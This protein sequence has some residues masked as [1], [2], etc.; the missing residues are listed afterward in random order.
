MALVM[1]VSVFASS[2]GGNVLISHASDEIIVEDGIEEI[3]QTPESA[4]EDAVIEGQ[5]IAED[6]V[7]AE[8]Q[9]IAENQVIAEDQVTVEEQTLPEETL[10]EEEAAPDDGDLTIEEIVVVEEEEIPEELRDTGTSDIGETPESNAQVTDQN[11]TGVTGFPASTDGYSNNDIALL[12]NDATFSAD[13]TV[14]YQQSAARS[15]LDLVNEFRTSGDGWYWNEDNITKVECG[16]LPA[17]TYDYTLEEIA[18]QRAAE[19]A[20]FFSH[21]RPDGGTCWTAYGN[22]YVNAYKAE[23]I[24]A[25]YTS[26]E[27]VFNAWKEENEY[28]DDQGHRRNMLSSTYTSIGIACV[29]YNGYYYWVQEFSSLIDSTT[30]TP[31]ND[32]ETK[33]TVDITAD[34]IKSL[35][36]TSSVEKYEMLVGDSM[37]L[38]TLTVKLFLD[39]S[40]LNPKESA[41][42]GSMESVVDVDYSWAVGDTSC[43]G[44]SDG[45]LVAKQVGTTELYTTV[46]TDDV[47]IPVTVTQ[48]ITACTVTLDPAECS[49]TG[50]A[51]TPTVTVMDGTTALTEGT[52][53]TVSYTDN[54]EVGT[55]TVTVTGMGSYSGEVTVDFTISPASIS[56]AVITFPDEKY[57][58]Y[59]GAQEPEVTVTVNGKVLEADTDYIVAYS[60]NVNAGEATVTVTGQGNYTD[61]ATATFTIDPADIS[62]ASVTFSQ[63]SYTYDG[64]EQTPEATVTWNGTELTAGTDYTIVYDNN[65]NVGRAAVTITGKGN[66]TGTIEE[67]F[68]IVQASIEDATVTVNP[69][70]Y[71]YDGEEKE[72]SVTVTAADGTSLTEGTDYSVSYSDNINAGEA[73]VTVTGMG[74]YE[75][76][77]SATFT[78]NQ[79]D[80]TDADVAVAQGSYTY[81]GSGQTPDVTVTVN[82][83]VLT[84]GT[85]YTVAY[86]DNVNAGEATVTVTGTGNYTG[87]A[88]TTFTIDPADLT[89]A[90]VTFAQDSYTYDGSEQTPDVT[91]T[92]DGTELTAGTDYT[93]VYDNNVNVGTAAVTITG[94]GNYTG[95]IEG[96][97]AIVQASIEDATITIDPDT[98]T[99]DGEEKEPSVTVTFNGTE[100]TEEI[101][102]TVSYSENIDAGEAAVTVTGMGNYEGTVAATFTINQADLTDADVA[103]AQ[104]SYTYDGSGQTPD[105][106]V[107]VNGKVLTVR[108]DYI[109]AYSN[110]VNAGEATVTVTGTGNYTG[111]ATA[112]FTIEQADISDASVTFV[113]DSYTYDGSAKTPA[114]TVTVNGTELTAGTDYT[115]VYSSNVNAGEATVT[116]TGTGNYT[117][118]ATADFTIDPADLSD[119]AVSVSDAVYS[120]EALSPEVTVT[121]ADG[122]VLKEDEDYTVTYSDN[123]DVGTGT[124]T[125][126]GIGNYTGTVTGTF[127][128]RQE[129]TEDLFTVDTD[130]ETYTGSEITKGITSDLTEDTDYTVSYADNTDAGTATIT[131]TGIGSYIGEL[132]YQFEIEPADITDAAVKLS[133][134]EYTYDGQ[135]KT[136]T[137]TVTLADGTVLTENTDYTVSYKNNIEAG[138]A[139]VTVT[140][141]GNYTGTVTASFTIDPAPETETE[142]ETPQ[143]ETETPQTET[144]TPQTETNAPQTETPQTE[145]SAPQTETS[146]PQTEAPQTET[147]AP[148]TEAPQ[149]ETETPQTDKPDTSKPSATTT[150]AL[151]ML[152]GTASKKTISLSWNKVQNAD[153]YVVYGKQCGKK[154][155]KLATIEGRKNTTWK[156]SGL[157][158]ATRYKFKV[159]AYKII[160]G[161]AKALKSSNMVHLVT[162]GNRFTNIKSVKVSENALSL[163][164]GRSRKVTAT[165]TLLDSNKRLVGHMGKIRYASSDKSVAVVSAKGK[166]TAVGK[167]TCVV[168]AYAPSGS[169]K[170][171][172]VTVK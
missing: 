103:V 97:F 150:T 16:V 73:A 172:T 28:Y 104:G 98:Y 157:K 159:Y 72:P 55:A 23:N 168:Y 24:A 37:G 144:N 111:E 169:R 47:I 140:G 155:R 151:L 92:V 7:I 83:K 160:N 21:T 158:Q 132:T 30:V 114:A 135:E 166:I 145:T 120:G 112:T 94:M 68:D 121:L 79:A 38:P 58:Y 66:Y 12:A 29:Y 35:S 18:M 51:Q 8:D 87:E 26:A 90:D 133:E 15:M 96:S 6:Q 105:V 41:F 4:E 113:P 70:A 108:T 9:I 107:T 2:V 20:L 106:T 82:G 153:G 5:I 11:I 62:A 162:A 99:Y 85:D 165:Y 31:A 131:I 44:I 154:L 48:S 67:Y 13:F 22:E 34:A 127:E 126:T 32:S 60:N 142:T 71:T 147:S 134:D 89:D 117:G 14:T 141:K 109:V 167:G 137:A 78:I 124:V 64:S 152:K 116:V 171:I 53:Y 75:G 119:A 40:L 101:D 45:Q 52:D 93:I 49:Y 36:V 163:R 81:D 149:T 56:D 27:A 77:A 128:I 46:F 102:Y 143:T 164:V 161:K 1:A 42:S 122:T 110:N 136:P 65:V 17:Y 148:Q 43:A 39:P 59:G 86:G 57:V 118:E 129:I 95:T 74:N 146:A 25:G 84:A 50:T 69:D 130:V 61:T 139:T 125:I 123:I 170:K 76:T 156:I 10:V 100:L 19:I 33:V 80:L 138:T 91:V 88:T 54:T 63:D 3:V 115:I